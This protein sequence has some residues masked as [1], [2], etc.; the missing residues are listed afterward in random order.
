MEIEESHGKIRPGPMT[1]FPVN[2][3]LRTWPI[4]MVDFPDFPINS[5]DIAIESSPV[6]GSFPI[7]IAW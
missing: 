3:N 7:F 4:E 2:A 5:M 1:G 6:I